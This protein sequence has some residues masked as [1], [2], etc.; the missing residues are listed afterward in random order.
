[1]SEGEIQCLTV[2]APLPYLRAMFVQLSTERK[3]I[4]FNFSSRVIENFAGSDKIE[5]AT[6][7]PEVLVLIVGEKKIKGIF[8]IKK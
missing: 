3:V 2:Y 4:K 7:P 1:M 6:R 8:Y 5:L